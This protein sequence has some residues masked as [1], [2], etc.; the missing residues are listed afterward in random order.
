[1]DP[2]AIAT[3]ATMLRE[4]ALNTLPMPTMPIDRAV[5]LLGGDPDDWDSF[6]F[7]EANAGRKAMKLYAY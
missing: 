4:N 3:L 5:G 6:V 1:M 7:N 2:G